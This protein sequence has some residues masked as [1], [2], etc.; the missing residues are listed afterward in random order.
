M[1]RLNGKLRSASFGCVLLA[2]ET[3][4]LGDLPDARKAVIARTIAMENITVEYSS[5]I[6]NLIVPNLPEGVNPH[7]DFKK[8]INETGTGIFRMRDGRV[9][10]EW[11]NDPDVVKAGTNHEAITIRNVVCIDLQGRAE[12]IE[13][14]TNMPKPIGRIRTDLENLL[15]DTWMADV[16]LGLRAFHAND[17]KIL[18]LFSKATPTFENGILS[19]KYEDKPLIHTWNFDEKLGFALTHYRV[20]TGG[21]RVDYECKNLKK[22]NDIFFPSAIVRTVSFATGPSGSFQIWQLQKLEL[23]KVV[24]GDPENNKDHTFQI[25]WPKGAII[26]DQRSGKS[27]GPL[28]QS[29]PLSDQDIPDLVAKRETARTKPTLSP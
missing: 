22:T 19:L 29:G 1:R 28:E 21:A 2:L 17:W 9:R 7:V 13:L 16:G 12:Q 18:D 25:D 23:S 8:G 6:E 14:D 27:F 20:E 10:W 4:A 15:I 5:T 24:V 11:I 26:H 3:L